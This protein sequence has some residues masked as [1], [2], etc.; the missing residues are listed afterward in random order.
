MMIFEPLV[1]EGYEWVN[2]C[3]DRDYET[4][5]AFDGQPRAATWRPIAV[6]RVQA[7]ER[8]AFKPS[9]FPWLGSHALVMRRTAVEALQGLLDLHGEVLP[10]ATNDI[11]NIAVRVQSRID[12]GRKGLSDNLEVRSHADELPCLKRGAR[13]DHLGVLG[14]DRPTCLPK[15]VGGPTHWGVVIQGP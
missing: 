13:A 14:R 10:L 3:D 9:D 12:G 8:Q 15:R 1:G 2:A 4:F 5:L 11:L 7:D 6:R